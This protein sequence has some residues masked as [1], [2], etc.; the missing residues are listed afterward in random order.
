MQNYHRLERIGEGSFGRV[1]KG[2]RK[3][4][5]QTVAMKFISKQG[6][7]EKDQAPLFWPEDYVAEKYDMS[8]DPCT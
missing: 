2:R 6:K 5:G 7:Q 4:T 8:L 1:F 3:C